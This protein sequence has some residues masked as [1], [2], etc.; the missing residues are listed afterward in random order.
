[1]PSKRTFYKTIIQVEVLSEEPIPDPLDL[2]QLYDET[3]DGEWSGRIVNMVSEELDG[4][5]AAK[6]LWNQGSDSE[7]FRLSE[8]GEDLE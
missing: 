3:Y 4:L 5:Q 1:M 7:F 2:G 6:A 8:D